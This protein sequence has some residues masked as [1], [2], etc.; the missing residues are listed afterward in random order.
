MSKEFI[1]YCEAHGIQRQLTA[2]Y[3][4]QQ[5]D[6]AECKNKTVVEMARTMLKEKNVSTVLWAKAV[7]TAVYILNRSPTNAV[8]EPAP[9]EPLKGSKPLVH[10]FTVFGC[11]GYVLNHS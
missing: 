2:P 5:N 1:G 3:T 4:P 7:A 9:Y 8:K 11:L 10:H 6:V